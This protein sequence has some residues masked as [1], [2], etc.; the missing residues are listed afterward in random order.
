ML[1]RIA[2]LASALGGFA[3]AVAWLMFLGRTVGPTVAAAE[4]APQPVVRPAADVSA[5]ACYIL[6]SE[7]EAELLD[8]MLYGPHVPAEYPKLARPSVSVV[9]GAT[10]AAVRELC[11]VAAASA[12][13]HPPPHPRVRVLDL[14]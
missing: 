9:T 13:G 5:F 6:A 12:T 1:H 3:L 7:G 10:G 8:K 11:G 14:R 2:V 4:F